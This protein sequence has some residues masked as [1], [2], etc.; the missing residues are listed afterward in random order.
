MASRHDDLAHR[1]DRPVKLETIKEAPLL[2]DIRLLGQI[3]GNTIREQE[4][5]VMFARIENIR[6]WRSGTHDDKT[7]RGILISING[8]AAGL[9]NT[10]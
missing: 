2:E 1:I 9:R 4:G 6:R 8:I 7:R 3:L 10:G 5:E